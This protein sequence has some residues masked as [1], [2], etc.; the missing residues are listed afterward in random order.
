[1]IDENP[2][3][4]YWRCVL[5]LLQCELGREDDARSTFER[6]A[7]GGFGEL[8]RDEDWLFG[9]TLIAELCA[10]LGDSRRAA[11]L[12]ELLLPYA[13][14]MALSPPNVSTGSVSRSL[15][16]LL[17][18]MARWDEAEQHF[19]TAQEAHVRMGARPWFARTER[20][21]GRM[22]LRRDGASKASPAPPPAP[23]TSRI[24]GNAFR[25]EGEYW[26]ITYEGKL[27][28]FKDA[29]GLHYIARLLREPGR[30]FHALELTAD[31]ESTFAAGDAGALL[32][33][34]AK[35]AYRRRLAELDAEM[36]NATSWADQGRAM[37]AGEEKDFLVRE[38]ARAVGL[39]GRDR[40]AASVAERARVN[41]T[42]AVRAALARVR[43][44]NPALGRH[45]DRAMR[46][47]MFCCYEP[48]PLLQMR[49]TVHLQPP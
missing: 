32:D 13:D 9:M 19:R 1:L 49:W 3:V 48:D 4:V 39:G 45:F 7:A 23:V 26:S 43:E 2:T 33:P 8:P 12:H 18:T 47:G 24:D 46:T 41:V 30:E 25:R 28:R 35:A 11:T 21:H 31:G 6:L 16:L 10:H 20:D 34:K 5:A 40:I 42:R 44:H 14:R 17:A 22:L 37:R 29:K 27:L 36:E 15:G 38:L